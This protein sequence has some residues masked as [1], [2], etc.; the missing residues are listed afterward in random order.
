MTGQVSMAPAD[1]RLLTLKQAEAYSGIS[2]W[3]LRDLIAAG[4]LPVVRPPGLR[5]LWL[6]RKDLDRAI[7]RWKERDH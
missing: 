2:I 4:D 7:E 3:T 5:R 6:D 1:V